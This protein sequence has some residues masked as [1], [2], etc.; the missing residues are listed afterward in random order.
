M[1]RNIL[2]LGASYGSLLATKLLMAGHNV[3][4]VCRKKTAELINRDGTEVRIKL[5]EEAMH[6]AIFSRD[7]PGTL[8]AT[9]PQEIDLSR[10]DLVALAMQEPQYANHTIR[11]LMIK[12]AGANLPCLS[13]MNMP[14]LPYLKRIPG[15]ADMDLEEAYTNAQVWERFK[16]GLVSLCSPDPQA[17]RPPEEAAN[18]LHVGL[19][20]NFKASTFADETHNLL[21]RELEADIDAVNLDGRDVP[22]KLRVFDSLFV[23][24]AKWSMLLTGNYRCITPQD[25]QSIRD[26]VHDD[27]KLS[28]TIY[29]HVDAIAR[30]LGADPKDQVPF[31]K[32]AKAAES[33]LKPSSAARAVASGAPFIERVDLLVKLISYQ[34]GM[35]NAEIDRTVQ[36]VD[37]KLNER[38][39]VGGS[40][41]P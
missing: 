29:D 41:A 1:A 28:Q 20:T 33:L 22:V 15:L 23:P 3:T 16:P 21:L 19:P 25:P 18:V 17:F 14:P 32:Y 8:D 40:G 12:I 13:I 7:L 26:A 39:V 10:Y 6:R 31:Q 34:L 38:I 4:L 2:I 11:V 37:Q 9:W 24:L 35:P 27:L 30:R 5:R 36:V